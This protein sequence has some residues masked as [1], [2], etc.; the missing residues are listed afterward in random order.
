MAT[1]DDLREL[2]DEVRRA[3]QALDD[4]RQRRDDA[5]RAV[6]RSTPHTVAEIASAAGVSEATV[7]TVIRG[8]R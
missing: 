5:I 6:R 8:M 7:K 1:L 3:T 2:A 4:L